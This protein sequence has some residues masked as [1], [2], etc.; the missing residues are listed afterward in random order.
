MQVKISTSKILF[1]DKWYSRCG[2]CLRNVVDFSERRCPG[3]GTIF[4]ACVAEFMF[5]GREREQ[6]T[7]ATGLPCIGIGSAISGEYDLYLD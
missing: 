5:F 6:C 3:C 4:E 2:K 1:V 7:I